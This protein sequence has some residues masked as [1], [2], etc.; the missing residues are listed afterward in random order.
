M[1]RG[2]N[3]GSILAQSGLA[4]GQNIAQAYQQ[5][6]Q[7]V[8]GMFTG[9]AGALE[10]RQEKRRAQSAQ[11]QFQQILGAYENNPDKLMEEALLAK[12]SP[13]VNLQR[14]GQLLEAQANRVR[15]EQEKAAAQRTA[16]ITGRGK[17]ELMA[18]ANNPQFNIMDQKQQSGYLRMANAFEVSPED[19][20]NIA[21]NALE[22]RDGKNGDF[23]KT[24][25]VTIRDSKGNEF[26]QYT[27]QDINNP[28]SDP[29]TKTIPVGSA[30]DKPE[31][32]TQIISDTTGASAFDKPGIAGE[33]RTEQ[34]FADLKVDATAQLPELMSQSRI[35]DDAVVA[36]DT[37]ESQGLPE[38][39]VNTIRKEFGVQDPDI[40]EYEMLVG[41]L[42]FSRLKPLF[43]GVISE[44]EREAIVGL[45]NDMKRG[46]PANKRILMQLQRKVKETIVKA[47]LIRRADS[48]DD[49]NTA[50]DR[51]YPTEE[52]KTEQNVID[53]NDLPT[54]G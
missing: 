39:V 44:G 50:L 23:R 17:G 14:M 6:G 47:N 41:E 43:G 13:D 28:Q 1:A 49:Y 42:M 7:G 11:E 40:A 30:P 15:E 27:I 21:L 19:A 36:L 29:I 8:G 53:F 24:D 2:S 54:Q 18:L 35:L 10:R 26:I 4:G 33:V 34:Q 37:M 20:M 12:N 3:I 51:M 31:G 25:Q 22:N 38:V 16:D 46:N 52:E 5:L 48:F 9:V 32:K 45:Y